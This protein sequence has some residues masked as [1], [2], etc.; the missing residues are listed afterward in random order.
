MKYSKPAL[1]ITDQIKLLE[2]RN[3]KIADQNRAAKY[4]SNISYYRLSGYMYPFK[5]LATSNFVGDVT[6]EQIIDL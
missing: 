5:D 2:S 3:L 4:L 1:T 6:F